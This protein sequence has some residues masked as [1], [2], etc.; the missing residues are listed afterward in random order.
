MKASLGVGICLL[1]MFLELLIKAREDSFLGQWEISIEKSIKSC[2]EQIASWY[3]F[4][5]TV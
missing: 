1:L 4:I 3:L 5:V 2:H